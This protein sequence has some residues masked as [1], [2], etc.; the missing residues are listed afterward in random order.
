MRQRQSPPCVSSSVRLCASPPLCLSLSPSPSISVSPSCCF[1]LSRAHA[2]AHA[3]TSQVN[4]EDDTHPFSAASCILQATPPP[5]MPRKGMGSH[6]PHL[7]FVLPATELSERE[8]FHQVPGSASDFPCGQN[9]HPC[10]KGAAG[11]CSQRERNRQIRKEPVRRESRE[12]GVQRVGQELG[13]NWQ[14]LGAEDP[15]AREPS[16]RHGAWEGLR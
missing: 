15:A 5:Q 10:R 3:E 16:P 1:S 2:H 8:H 4:N 12:R 6:P 13:R 14:S 9:K 7:P 11:L